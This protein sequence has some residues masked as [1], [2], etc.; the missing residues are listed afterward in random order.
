MKKTA[1]DVSTIRAKVKK[2][3][4]LH[5]AQD[6]SDDE[7]VDV[8]SENEETL[9]DGENKKQQDDDALIEVN[10]DNECISWADIQAYIRHESA[11]PN[12]VST[13]SNMLLL[14]LNK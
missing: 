2:H 6:L 7:D 12:L 3:L 14:P 4:H 5:W 1:D 13:N 8:D 10:L 9:K 11:F